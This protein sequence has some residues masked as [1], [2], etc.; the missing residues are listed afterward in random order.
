MLFFS[1][2]VKHGL[3]MNLRDDLRDNTLHS[4]RREYSPRQNIY[5]RFNFHD[6]NHYSQT[7]RFNN[8]SVMD[9]FKDL[10]AIVDYFKMLHQVMATASNLDQRKSWAWTLAK[11]GATYD[12]NV[13]RWI[14][15]YAINYMSGHFLTPCKK[16]INPR[17]HQW[18]YIV[19]SFQGC[20]S[21]FKAD[22]FIDA[23]L[24][25]YILSC[26]LG[27]EREKLKRTG[28]CFDKNPPKETILELQIIRFNT[29]ISTKENFTE[30]Q[31]Y[32]CFLFLYE[33]TSQIY[34]ESRE[35]FNKL[36]CPDDESHLK[37]CIDLL[38]MR[39][40]KN[41]LN[42]IIQGL[43]KA[44]TG[45][46]G[47]IEPTRI[48]LECYN[49]WRFNIPLEDE[50]MKRGLEKLNSLRGKRRIPLTFSYGSDGKAK[51]R[52]KNRAASVT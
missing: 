12:I 47:W 17:F 32:F 23:A 10:G 42:D 14:L 31:N 36:G 49:S 19:R 28:Y 51:N 15:N 35:S 37:L 16:K 40:I 2:S 48:F 38:L 34:R 5:N 24:D 27:G 30:S 3:S 8:E 18:V 22:L 6:V 44:Q 1:L 9:Y 25:T 4:M 26:D 7:N 50:N 46:S 29:F 52:R 41:P 11:I 13:Q 39:R 45:E 21:N 43:V 20:Y 33:K